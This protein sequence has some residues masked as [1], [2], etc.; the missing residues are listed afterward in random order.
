[1]VG[2]K[3]SSVLALDS[4]TGNLLTTSRVHPKKPSKALFMQ[5]LGKCYWLQVS[6]FTGGLI[7]KSV[8]HVD[9]LKYSFMVS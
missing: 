5:T 8:S 7:K 3:D 6:Y 9:R 4:D 2:T 1:M